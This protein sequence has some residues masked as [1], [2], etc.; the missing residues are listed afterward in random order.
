LIPVAETAA[1]FLS[2]NGSSAAD[3]LHLKAWLQEQRGIPEGLLRFDASMIP[4]HLTVHIRVTQDG[5]DLAQGTDLRA[6]RRQCAVAGRTEL[7]RQARTAYG[8]LGAW[9]RFEAEELPARVSLPLP[10]G[11]IPLF[12]ALARH[13]SALQVRFE[14]SLEEA[15]RD[16]RDGA[17][18][19]A[20]IALERQARDLSKSI[21]ANVPLCLSASP[22]MSSDALIDTLLQLGFRAACFGEAEAPRTRATFDEALDRGRERIYP[23]VEDASG[24]M[25]SWLKEAAQ[26]RQ[27]LEDSR[28]K[29]LPAAA[30][31]TRQHLRRLF[32]PAMLQIMPID[33]LRQRPRYLK[34]ELRRW[35]RNSVRGSEA[36]HIINELERWS[37]CYQ[38]LKKQLDAELRWIPQLD[39]LRFWIEEYRVSLYAQELKTLGPISSARL[40]Q[41]AEEIESWLYR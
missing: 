17:V 30:E 10:Q 22:Y 32:E 33:W 15:Q 21:A 12:P 2:G 36:A 11:A 41:R 38:D 23:C 25:A 35:Q 8:L 34:A 28:L 18:R 20:R 19:L 27:A 9:R 16:W 7:D 6:L 5:R 31:E 14:H 26:L 37:L 24:L 1:K 40:Q 39:E 3:P 13:E 29:L 4:P